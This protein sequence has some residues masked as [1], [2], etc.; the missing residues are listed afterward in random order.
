MVYLYE[1]FEHE[2]LAQNSPKAHL[3]LGGLMS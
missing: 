2:V 3:H 1:I